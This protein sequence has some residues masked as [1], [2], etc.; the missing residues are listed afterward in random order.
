MM[1]EDWEPGKPFLIPDPTDPTGKR[2]IE[3]PAD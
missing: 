2:M 1:P 3:I